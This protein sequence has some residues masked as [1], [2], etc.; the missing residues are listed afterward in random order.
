[1]LDVFHHSSQGDQSK[2]NKRKWFMNAD[3]NKDEFLDREEYGR[4]MNPERY[5]DAVEFIVGKFI[6]GMKNILS[7][8]LP[9]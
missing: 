9:R 5:F 8:L 4:L 1:M 6:R 2:E 7:S 3:R